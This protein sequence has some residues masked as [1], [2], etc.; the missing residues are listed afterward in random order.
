M[1]ACFGLSSLVVGGV[2]S[3]ETA[4]TRGLMHRACAQWDEQRVDWCINEWSISQSASGIIR[5]IMHLSPVIVH[6]T[7]Q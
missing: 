2:K 4:E 7:R 5:I 1:S 3:A 6:I